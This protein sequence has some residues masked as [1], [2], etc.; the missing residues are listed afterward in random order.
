LF[1]AR[2]S[3]SWP[4]FAVNLTLLPLGIVLFDPLYR[5]FEAERYFLLRVR[6]VLAVV[7]TLSLWLFT[8][9]AGMLGVIGMVVLTAIIERAVMAI[10]FGRL[11]GVTAGDIGLL[12]D[13]GKLAIAAT[14]AGI[15]AGLARRL[16]LSENAFV[17]L[18]VCGAVFAALYLG[19][20]GFWVVGVKLANGAR[21]PV[22]K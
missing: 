8:A 11:L 7:L 1:T 9:R 16:V 18:A 3:D 22:P 20:A 2:F 6:L 12:R 19:M 14:A 13:V 10:H 15:A 21:S 4:I 17:V 5:A